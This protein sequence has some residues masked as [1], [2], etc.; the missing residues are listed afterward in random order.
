MLD[1]L[2]IKCQRY[3]VRRNKMLSIFTDPTVIKRSINMLTGHVDPVVE[4]SKI[5]ER[6]SEAFKLSVIFFKNKPIF[7]LT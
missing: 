6:F 7:Y 2:V 3:F 4:N 1:R 5:L